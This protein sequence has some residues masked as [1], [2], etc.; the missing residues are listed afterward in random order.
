MTAMVTP[1]FD[2]PRVPHFK[3]MSID[4][5][6]TEIDNHRAITNPPSFTKKRGPGRPSKYQIDLPAV[7]EEA[8][9]MIYDLMDDNTPGECR[10][11]FSSSDKHELE[12][13]EN[14]LFR[15]VTATPGK[16][17]YY[18]CAKKPDGSVIGAPWLMDMQERCVLG[19]GVTE[20]KRPTPEPPPKPVHI[21]EQWPPP[22]EILTVLQASV[23]LR[24]LTMKKEQPDSMIMDSFRILFSMLGLSNESIDDRMAIITRADYTALESIRLWA[25][26]A[27]FSNK[28]K[29]FWYACTLLNRHL[30]YPVF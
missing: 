17:F 11:V 29:A 13:V 21:S 5:L 20:A 12:G 16:R 23:G 19:Y 25:L 26:E 7:A 9:Y 15:M 1:P 4:E 10:F 3:G 24:N 14:F 6:V 30:F 22:Q 2:D 8:R 28:P 27:Y 18:C